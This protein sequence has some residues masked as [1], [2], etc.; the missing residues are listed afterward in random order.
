[1]SYLLVREVLEHCPDLPYRQ[2]RVLV[3]LAD[4]ASPETRQCKPGM[5]ALAVRGNCSI[6]TV[7]SAL[8]GLRERTLI[9]T[10][11]QPG[12]GKR[13]T[14]EVVLMPGTGASKAASVTDA[15]KVAPVRRSTDV[16]RTPIRPGTHASKVAPSKGVPTE[17]LLKVELPSGAP[18][19]PGTNE[20]LAAFIDWD[21]ERGGKLTRRTIGILARHIGALHAEGIPEK[22]IRQGLVAWRGSGKYPSTLHSFVDAAMAPPAAPAPSRRQSERDAMF[23]RAMARAKA[24]DAARERGEPE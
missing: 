19:A 7:S 24:R 13:A 22:H 16:E 8:A 20:T 18:S 6:R 15:S 5:A 2:F 23:D 12:P 17:P 14:F 11:E 9:K 4:D 10:V 1:M 21:R 3:A